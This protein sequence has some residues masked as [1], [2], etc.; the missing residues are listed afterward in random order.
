M[1]STKTV[2][3][4]LFLCLSTAFFQANAQNPEWEEQKEI[5]IS[6]EKEA[7]K[8]KIIEINQRLENKEITEEEAEELRKKAA[9]LHAM[10]IKNRLEILK[11]KYALEERNDDFS[12]D[13]YSADSDVDFEQNS[14]ERN[15]EDRTSSDIVIAAGFSNALQEGQALDDSDFKIGGSRFFEIGWSWKTRVFKESNWLRL[16]YGFSFRF[17]GFKPTENRYLVEN[18]ELTVLEEFPLDLEKSKFRRDNLIFP[19]YFEIGPSSKTVTETD[20]YFSTHD[21]L[22]LGLGGYAGINIGER[23]KLKYEEDGEN[24]KEKIKNDYNTNDL[25]YGLSA[26]LGWNDTALYFNYGLNPIFEEPNP[27]L[28]YVSLGLRFNID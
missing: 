14:D 11:N 28:H 6:E 12:E 18:E 13:G 9:R 20:V 2:F 24:V 23:Q 22:K 1:K 15:Y 26:Y 10:N 16:R 27:A 17:N 8:A 4:L 5:I 25:V 19:V 7:L 21:K 3:T